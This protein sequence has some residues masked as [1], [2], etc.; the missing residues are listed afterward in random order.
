MKK[1]LQLKSAG[2]TL[3][4]VMFLVAFSTV[5]G[6]ALLTMGMQQR[7]FA[8]RTGEEIAARCAADAGITKALWVMNDM[9]AKQT[10]SAS[11]LPQETDVGLSNCDATYSYEITASS[12]M[13]ATDYQI[14][15]IGKCGVD[16]RTVYGLVRLQGAGECGVLVQGK[17]ILKSGT[18]VDGRDS[19]LP[20]DDP[21]QNSVGVQIGTTS[22]SPDKM[23]LNNGVFINGDVLVGYGGNPD[24]VIKDLGA[25]VTGYKGSLDEE[26]TFPAVTPPSGLLNKGKIE[27]KGKDQILT[28]LDSGSYT[29]I[30]L[31]QQ[32]GV[33]ANLVIVPVKVGGEVLRKVV[34]HITGDVELGQGCEIQIRTIKMDING[35]GLDEDVSASLELYVNGDIKSGE[36]SGF[37]NQG[38]PPDLKLWGTANSGKQQPYQ[39]FQLNAKSEYFGQVYAPNASLEVKANGDL[40]GAFTAYSFEMKS[41][42]NLFYDGALRKT[43]ITEPA[44]HF[45]LK[46][47]SAE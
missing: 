21:R 8:V 18:I 45:V 17:V 24:T 31:Q 38:T 32:A 25:T 35:D 46:R 7:I 3:A 41:G 6:V 44:A 28:P 37:G 43:D 1:T 36:D 26:P 29:R 10:F 19:G 15:A 39:Q 13:A 12:I 30:D 23:V 34:L 11:N 40:Y 47:W 4:M 27:V 16:E 33:D 14:E 42:G 2:S 5:L 20:L 9:L 22:I